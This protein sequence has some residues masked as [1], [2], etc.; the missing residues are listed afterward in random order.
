MKN[1]EQLKGAIRNFAKKNSLRALDVQYMVLFEHI[2]ERLSVS[3]YSH[4]FVL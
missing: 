2:L 4:N 1:P 3:P